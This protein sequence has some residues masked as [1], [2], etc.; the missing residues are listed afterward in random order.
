MGRSNARG[1]KR[2]GG[3]VRS[4]VEEAVE[5]SQAE[6]NDITA[7]PNTS[8]KPVGESCFVKE[9][10]F[11]NHRWRSHHRRQSSI[12]DGDVRDSDYQCVVLFF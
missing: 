11:W 3:R 10:V 9:E 8:D 1:A 5:D 7:E 4:D 6:L 12:Y 2:A